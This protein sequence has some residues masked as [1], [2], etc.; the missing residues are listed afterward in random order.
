[1]ENVAADK[2][3]TAQREMR[4]KN[5]KF[6][7]VFGHQN[8]KGGVR[9]NLMSTGQEYSNFRSPC[10]SSLQSAERTVRREV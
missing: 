4:S 7:S 3:V 2:T 8:F 10:Q 1:M 5:A 9:G 6:G